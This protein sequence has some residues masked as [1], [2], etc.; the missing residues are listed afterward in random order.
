MCLGCTAKNRL[1]NEFSQERN[2]KIVAKIR[3]QNWLDNH[4]TLANVL[5]TRGGKIISAECLVLMLLL[6]VDSCFV[7]FDC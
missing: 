1:D 2:C 7:L 3:L 5:K 6:T 4:I